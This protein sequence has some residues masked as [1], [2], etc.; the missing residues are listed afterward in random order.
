MLTISSLPR[1]DGDGRDLEDTFFPKGHLKRRDDH[2]R[3]NYA[4]FEPA[5]DLLRGADRNHNTWLHFYASTE[6]PEAEIIK[7][8]VRSF[9]GRC[10]TNLTYIVDPMPFGLVDNIDVILATVD[11]ADLETESMQPERQLWWQHGVPWIKEMT[12]EL[13]VPKHPGPS[14]QQMVEPESQFNS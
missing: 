9:C 10:G 8:V 13:P 2:T 1:K 14:P 12:K 3:E 6:N 5:F 4:P 7:R 11:R